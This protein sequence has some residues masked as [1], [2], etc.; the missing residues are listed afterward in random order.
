TSSVSPELLH[1]FARGLAPVA[2]L[3]NITLLLINM[4]VIWRASL[5]KNCEQADQ[6]NNSGETE[7]VVKS[8]RVARF[9]RRKFN[10]LFPLQ[11]YY[12]AAA[13]TFLTLFQHL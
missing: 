12:V 2:F 13:V 3:R 1:G 10:V 8:V 9:D 5:L 11:L 4:K 6:C 7:E